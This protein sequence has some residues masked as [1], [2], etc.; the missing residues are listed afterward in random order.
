ASL[1]ADP[2][3]A[4]DANRVVA[5]ARDAG[6]KQIDYLLITHFHADH[7]GAVPELAQL[8][9]IRAFVDH[10]SPAADAEARVAGTQAAFDRYA[11]VRATG[12]HL[13]PKPGAK[14]PLAG[15]DVTVVSSGGE[16]LRTPLAGAG[17]A[18]HT[19]GATAPPAQEPTENPRSTGVFMRFGRFTFLD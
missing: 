11:R 4:R 3:R 5:A 15:V 19:C 6:I 12:R 17:A 18:N 9:P 7:D 13:S 2:A 10:D 16:T 8:I 1:S 14:I